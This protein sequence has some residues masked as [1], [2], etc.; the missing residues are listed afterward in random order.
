MEEK[1]GVTINKGDIIVG[2][3]RK[4]TAALHPIVYI[5]GDLEKDFTGVMLTKS[6][7]YPDNIRMEKEHF[8]EQDAE[9]TKF[10]TQ[11]EDSHFVKVKLMKKIE[12]G[13]FTKTG[14]LTEIGIKFIESK[15]QDLKPIYWEG[16]LKDKPSK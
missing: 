4:P 7:L 8:K 9:G 16:Y 10:V 1:K 12:W 14:E 13:P 15:L 6:G 3:D 5:E 11:F 2:S